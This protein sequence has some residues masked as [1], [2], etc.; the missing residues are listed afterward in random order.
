M[1]RTHRP[2]PLSIQKGANGDAAHQREPSDIKQEGFLQDNTDNMHASYVYKRRKLRNSVALLSEDNDM[3]STKGSSAC[4]SSPKSRCIS[5]EKF[6]HHVQGIPTLPIS[7]SSSTRS[8]THKAI[9]V[10]T[11]QP[12]DTRYL[13]FSSNHAMERQ[14]QPVDKA[15]QLASGYKSVNDSCSSS[16]SNMAKGSSLKNTEMDDDEECSLSSKVIVELLVKHGSAR[17]TCISA[18]VSCDQPGDRP[19]NSVCSSIDELFGN[20]TLCLSCK[21]CGCKDNQLKMLICDLCEEAFH[22]SCSKVRKLPVYDWYCQPCLRKKSKLLP[23]TLSGKLFSTMSEKQRKKVLQEKLGPI[24]CMLEDTSPYTSGVRIGKDFQVEVPEWTGPVTDDDD[25]F[26]EPLEL[27]PAECYSLNDWSIKRS[28]RPSSIGN[29]LQCRAMIQNE[30]EGV[31]CGKWRR[32]PL[33]VAQ[34]QDWDCSCALPWDPIHADCAVPQ[35]LDTSEVLKQLK[36]IEL[37]VR[38]SRDMPCDCP[39]VPEKGIQS[40]ISGHYNIS[41]KAD[42]ADGAI[43][44][45]VVWLKSTEKQAVPH[46]PSPAYMFDKTMYLPE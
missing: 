9:D 29:W 25:Y 16:K 42:C 39:R 1:L 30:D 26:D 3:G 15:H 6:N 13:L 19:N 12:D 8:P 37:V 5:L 45:T 27:G 20:D 31:I 24:L 7:T 34:T 44:H 10:L 46:I 43:A 14:R 32:A 22:L 36:Y 38:D 17:D 23:E 18:F 35:E 11:S 33:F 21:L 41:R 2:M 4:N 28:S 40:R